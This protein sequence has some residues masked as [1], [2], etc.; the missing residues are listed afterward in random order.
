MLWMKV[1]PWRW[2]RCVLNGI[3]HCFNKISIEVFVTCHYE[4]SKWL[5][6]Q[7][8]ESA[9][10][11][12]LVSALLRSITSFIWVPRRANP[13]VLESFMALLKHPWWIRWDQCQMVSKDRW[14]RRQI[15]LAFHLSLPSRNTSGDMQRKVDECQ[16]VVVACQAALEA[17]RHEYTS[18]HLMLKLLWNNKQVMKSMETKEKW[19][20]K[21]IV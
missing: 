1:E 11:L 13:W 8:A 19:L 9:I 16:R 5:Q 2:S 15:A 21:E 7:V 14:K 10:F 3:W 4:I 20:N 17:N 12:N 6:L 18:E